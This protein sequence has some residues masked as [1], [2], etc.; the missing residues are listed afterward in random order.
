MSPE[1]HRVSHRVIHAIVSAA[2]LA[3]STAWAHDPSA[4]GGLFRSRDFGGAWLNADVGLFLGGAVSVAVNPAD[5]NHLLLGTDSGLLSSRA[6]GRSWKQESPGMMFGAVTAVSFLAGGSISLC[7]TPAGVFRLE[8]AEWQNVAAP[9]E[10]APA[11]AIVAGAGAGRVYLVGRRDLFRSDDQGRQWQRVDHALPDQPEFAELAVALV[12]RETLYAIVDGRPMASSDGGSSWTPREAGLPGA[13]AEALTV[14]PHAAGRLWVASGDRLYVSEDNDGRWRPVG[15]ALPEAN[16]TVRAIAADVAMQKIIVTTHR[17]MYRSVNGAKSWA[18]L[19]GNLPVHLES[20]P[21]VRDPAHAETLY[22]GYSLMPY[23][24]IWRIA[25]EG[26][27]L[28]G[29]IDWLSLAGGLA[30]LL[31]LGLLGA[32]AA[33]RLSRRSAPARPLRR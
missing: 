7:T 16:T 10:A 28:L 30:L 32:L 13:R 21:L 8:G 29:R 11:R 5:S 4:Y 20:K 14:D 19:E 26:G 9:A 18:L 12:P 27:N 22:A 3:C 33:R 23:G 1:V 17:G 31:L 6:G 15:A 25:V 2:V 24:E